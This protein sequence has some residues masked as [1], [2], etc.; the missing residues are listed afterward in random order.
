M[1]QEE[2]HR[3]FTDPPTLSPERLILRR[4]AV[5]DA[6]D[7]YLYSCRE[8]VTR[9]L[10]WDPHPDPLY[11]EKYIRYLQ[12]R[13]AVGDFY[14]FAV[15]LRETGRLIG[16]AG[17]TSFDLPN[18]SA[19]IGYVISPLYQ[20]CGYATEA[21]RALVA[22]GFEQCDLSRI[23]AVCMRENSASLR[24]MEKCGL[25]REGLLRSAV[26]AK[27]EMQ[28]VHLAAITSHDYFNTACT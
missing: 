4:I 14:D 6:D 24:V 1:T 23:S 26:Y 7:M 18:R 9:Y 13:Y 16:T 22:F 12:E 28:D 25:K 20:G 27:G 10:L 8:D 5:S 19:E 15:V 17:F 21:V 11:T 3:T 2:L